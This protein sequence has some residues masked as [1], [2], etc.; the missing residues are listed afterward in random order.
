MGDRA[1][2]RSEEVW[3]YLVVSDPGQA[4][5]LPD[6]EEWARDY[7]AMHGWDLTKI[8]RG[9]DSGRAGTRGLCDRM[10]DAIEALPKESRPSRV[11][12][13]RL[14]RIGRGT[15]LGPFL[16]FAKLCSLG[17]AGPVPWTLSA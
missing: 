3:A 14:D 10:V 8:Y 5:T 2:G 13:I 6:Q 1:I 9:V 12:M 15:G 4:H 17:E 11:L 7:A 16:A